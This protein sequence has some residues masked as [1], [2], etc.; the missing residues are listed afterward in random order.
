MI[1]LDTNVLVRFLV[2]DDKHQSQAATRLI[3]G[4][5]DFF[6]NVIVLC[7]LVWVLESCYDLKKQ[8]T[9]NTIEKILTTRQFTVENSDVV[10]GA[11]DDFKADEA[12]FADCLIGK[13]NRQKECLYTASFDK[14]V[15]R[16]QT[17]K[18]VPKASL[19]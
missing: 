15:K 4:G 2:Q 1:G 11:L 14:A 7:E 17:F 9:V 3:E 13:I 5:Q 12:D 10:W 16:L 19:S 6:I 18:L 8:D